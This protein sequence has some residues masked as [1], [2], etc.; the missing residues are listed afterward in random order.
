M[1]ERLDGTLRRSSAAERPALAA[2]IRALRSRAGASVGAGTE[3]VLRELAKIP[4][5]DAGTWL[6]ACERELACALPRAGASADQPVEALVVLLLESDGTDLG[7]APP[8]HTAGSLTGSRHAAILEGH[9]GK[10]RT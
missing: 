1:L 8:T 6:S 2:R 4:W 3:H 5:N 9:K 7:H 10:R